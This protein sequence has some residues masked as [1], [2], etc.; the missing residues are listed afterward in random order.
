MTTNIRIYGKEEIESR[1]HSVNKDFVH[2]ISIGDGIFG[3]AEVNLSNFKSSI[4][5]SFV[6]FRNKAKGEMPVAPFIRALEYYKTIPESDVIYI[7]C[8]AGISRSTAI[9]TLLLTFKYNNDFKKA[10]EQVYQ[11]RQVASP[12]PW[13]IE[14]GLKHLLETDNVAEYIVL[15]K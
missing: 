2:L 7:N 8:Y 3:F 1:Q 6:D 12:N 10:L 11:I 13:L 9:A 15:L 14:L 5:L 4:I